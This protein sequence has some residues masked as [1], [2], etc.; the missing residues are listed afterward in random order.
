MILGTLIEN[1]ITFF[2]FK[3]NNPSKYQTPSIV[4]YFF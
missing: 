1:V 2:L 4:K 3:Y